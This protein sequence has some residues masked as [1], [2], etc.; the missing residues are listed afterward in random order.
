M[1]QIRQPL[2]IFLSHDWP[3]GITNFGNV[4]ELLKIK[5]FFGPD[6]SL[7]IQISII[8]IHKTIV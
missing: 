3:T 1:N 7:L 5:P 6:V 8:Y 4:D 2:D